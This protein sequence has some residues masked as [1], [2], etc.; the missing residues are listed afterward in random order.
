VAPV[1]A[2]AAYSSAVDPSI[3]YDTSRSGVDASL[4]V[5]ARVAPTDESYVTYLKFCLGE[6]GFSAEAM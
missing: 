6:G 1:T 2:D 3:Q 4:F 5:G